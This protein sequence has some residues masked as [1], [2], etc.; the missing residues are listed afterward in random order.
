MY[1]YVKGKSMKKSAF[2]FPA[3]LSLAGAAHAQSSVTLYGVVDSGL[4]FISNAKGGHLYQMNS[5]T[6]NPNRWGL[7]G[8]EDLGAGLATIFTIEGGFNIANGTL[9][10]NGTEFGRQAFVG[11]DT[12]YGT[13]T[14]GR[15]IAGSFFAVGSVEAGGDWAAAGTGYGAHPGDADNLDTSNRIANALKFKTKTYGGFTA[16]G[17]YG[18]GGKPGEFSQNSAWDFGATYVNGPVRLAAGY[19]FVKDPNFSFWGNKANDSTTGSNIS[20]PVISGYATA[21]SQQVISG[22]ATYYVG[23][24][25]I[26][27]LYSNAQFQNLGTV[28]VAG[29]SASE[30]ALRGTATFNTGEVN[31]KYIVNPALSFGAAY[32]YTRNS[33]A[34][35]ASTA[36]YQQVD[37]GAFYNISKRTSFY[38][39]AVFEAAAGKD[40][41]GESAVAAITGATPSSTNRQVVAT[42]GMSHRF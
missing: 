19:L 34:T 14:A 4:T 30:Q 6:E 38:A 9:G 3:L 20:S 22:A 7:T 15:Q 10:Q 5:G 11:L 23:P 28:A 17:T 40:S 25:I 41:T 26:T 29:L 12:P 37:L 33:G 13:V 1:S 42:V 8:R 24:A 27:L 32:F 16:S 35:N 39:V 36:H 21:G 2:L 31:V 18:F